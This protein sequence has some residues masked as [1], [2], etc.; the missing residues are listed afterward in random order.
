[1]GSCIPITGQSAWEGSFL[2]GQPAVSCEA[3]TVDGGWA[4]GASWGWGGSGE[5]E[6]AG[7]GGCWV[8]HGDHCPGDPRAHWLRDEQ[9]GQLLKVGGK[10]RLGGSGAQF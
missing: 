4:E 2:L 6:K 7:R 1:M 3:V 8:V 10:A 9:G 5:A